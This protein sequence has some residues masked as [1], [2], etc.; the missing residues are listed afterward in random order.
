[1]TSNKVSKSTI[2]D[3]FAP[4]IG[5]NVSHLVLGSMPGQAS[6]AVEQYYA[7]PR[8]AFWPIIMGWLGATSCT[9]YA[10]RCRLLRRSPIVLWDVLASCVRPGSLDSDILADTVVVND[11][12]GL[13]ASHPRLNTIL[14][15]GAAAERLFLKHALPSLADRGAALSL[16]RMPSTSPA[17][18]A[19]RFE[20]KQRQWLRVLPPVA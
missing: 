9:Q 3:G 1:M 2:S 19:M 8:N 20:E 4:I 13:M 6:L 10:D 14:F 7:H 12:A 16:L 15:N 5:E 11:F 18:A 17:Y